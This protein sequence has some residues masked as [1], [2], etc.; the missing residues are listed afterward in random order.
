[1][2]ATTMNLFAPGHLAGGRL[3]CAV[4]RDGDEEDDQDHRDPEQRSL[5][6]APAAIAVDSP[7]NVDESPVPRAWSQDRARDAIAMT[8]WVI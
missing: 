5:K 8:I 2:R 7:P 6:P 1:M 4:E 3:P